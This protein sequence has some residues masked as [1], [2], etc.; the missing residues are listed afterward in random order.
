[1]GDVEL[2]AAGVDGAQHLLQHLGLPVFGAIWP[3]GPAVLADPDG[4]RVRD[5]SQRQRL[6]AQGAQHL[7]DRRIQV[8]LLDPAA[9]HIGVHVDAHVI[10]A[11]LEP[12]AAQ[13]RH[14]GPEGARLGFL[15]TCEQGLD[16]LVT[17]GRP[18]PAAGPSYAGLAELAYQRD[19][20][21]LA[22]RHA[23]EA[24]ALCRQFV[25]TPPLA[26]GLATLAMIRQA[27]GDPAGALEAITEA[28]QAAAG[29]AGLLNPVP[30]RRARLLLAQ[31]DLPAATRFAR[32]N[33][34]G[35]DD[36]ADYARESG[37]LV[38]ARILLA[39]DRPGQSLALLD[40][41]HAAAK[42][43]DRAGSIIETGALRALALAATGAEASAV[44]ALAG[45]LALACPQGYVRVF[46]DE[47]PPMAALLGRPIAAQRAGDAAAGVPLGCLA[48]LQRAFGAGPL[49]P[50]AVPSGIVDPLTGRELEVLEMLAAGRSNQ[51]I[52]RELVVTLDTVK[53]HVGHVLAKLGAANRTEAVTRARELSLIS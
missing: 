20:L 11:G 34:L 18:P 43:Q 23:G 12:G 6:V 33:G 17:S 21:D 13:R 22:L 41:L 31:G 16:T 40:R 9:E 29:P 48:R 8:R 47:G 38:L 39:Q 52:A 28:G 44:T 32:D 37:H 35:P 24:I 27:T 30:A 53:K 45:A 14:G 36:E 3:G 26:N 46:A 19:E 15:L 42:A 50:D 25:Y 51:A 10:D 4:G 49:A 7:P 2:V 5:A 1:V